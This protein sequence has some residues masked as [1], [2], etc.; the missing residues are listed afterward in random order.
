MTDPQPLAQAVAE[1]S[2]VIKDVSITGMLLYALKSVLKLEWVPG[3]YYKDQVARAEKAE[4]HATLAA[5]A[6]DRATR[7]S[8]QLVGILKGMNL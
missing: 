6:A 2:S 1:W 5:D 4:A 7:V 3:A 8:E